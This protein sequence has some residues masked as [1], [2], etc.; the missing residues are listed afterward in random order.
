MRPDKCFEGSEWRYGAKDDAYF[1][2]GEGF[3]LTSEK[4][5][6]LFDHQKEGV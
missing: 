6:K 3:G 4:Y 2:K 1:L 5:L